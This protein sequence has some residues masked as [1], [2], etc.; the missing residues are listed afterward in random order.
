MT[1]IQTIRDDLAE[2]PNFCPAETHNAIPSLRHFEPLSQNE[3][4]SIINNLGTK[5]CESDIISTQL[6]KTCLPGLLPSITKIVNV[7]L[8]SGVFP[9][10]YKEAIVRPLL[11][12]PGLDLVCSNYRPVSNLTFLS[13]VLEKAM[14]PRFNKHCNEYNLLPENQ[15]AYRPNFS[16]ETALLKLTN[17]ILVAMED[18]EITSL[19][20]I[21]LSA[22]F[23]TVDHS[24]LLN[25]LEKRF[26]V[27][28]TALN[29]V[30]TY[31]SP[32]SCKVNIGKSYSTPHDLKFCVPQS[33]CSGLIFF[34]AYISTL[35]DIIPNEIDMFGFADDYILKNRFNP[36]VANAELNAI[37]NLEHVNL[38]VK[39]WMMLTN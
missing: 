19:V 33:S 39:K 1:K 13:K 8:S 7:C 11:K 28:G 9:N 35:G 31:L 12:K 21:D 37:T 3:V 2:I 24:I 27:C 18:K 10:N 14:L 26:G 25:V 6:L 22:A 17:D 15:S 30:N 38:E 36:K 32:R 34:L 4:K 5:S 16:C 29:W 20:A 23:D